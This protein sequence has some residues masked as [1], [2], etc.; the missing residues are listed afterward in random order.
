MGEAGLFDEDSRVELIDGEV[1]QMAAIGHPHFVCV[2]RLN[3]L[4]VMAVG[5]RA[6]VSVQNPVQLDDYSEPQPDLAVLDPAMDDYDGVNPLAKDVY[7]L[8]EV[9]DTTL[10][11][12]IGFKT[13]R[14]ARAGI[15]ACWVVGLNAGEVVVHVDPGPDGYRS[16]HRAQPGEVLEVESLPG[17]EVSVAEVLGPVRQSPPAGRDDEGAGSDQKEEP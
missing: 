6:V 2:N 16:V 9:A 1:F 15:P 14:Y 8:V 13:P 11:W 12:D 5:G 4:L 3:R 10:N 7:L 17:V